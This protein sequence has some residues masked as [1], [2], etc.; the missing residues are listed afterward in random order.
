MSLG[1]L[2]WV[3]VSEFFPYFV[4]SAAPSVCLIALTGWS[5]FMILFYMAY[6]KA[7]GVS[8]AL[9]TTASITFIGISVLSFLI[10]KTKGVNIEK[11]YRLV[12]PKFN[13]W[14]RALGYADSNEEN[15]SLFDVVDEDTGSAGEGVPLIQT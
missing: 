5:S 11:V 14:W 13:A 1:S 3:L 8:G 10:P 2:A 4:R 12:P 6:Q 15:R 7:V 9:A